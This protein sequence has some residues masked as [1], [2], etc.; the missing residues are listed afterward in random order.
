VRSPLLCQTKRGICRKCYGTDFTTNEP[1]DIGMP[2]GVVA[3]QSIGE[4]GTQ[5]TMRVRH[6]GGIVISDVTQGLPRVEELLETRTPKIISPIAEI[7]GK[8]KIKEDSENELYQIEIASLDKKTTKYYQIPMTQKLHIKNGQLITKGTQLSEGYLDIK[9]VLEIRGIRS[10]Q[11]YL[12]HEIQNVY[13]SQGI[14]IHDK[15]FEVIIRKMSDKIIIDDEGD[16]NFLMGEAVNKDVFVEE[17]KKIVAKGGKPASGKAKV[18]GITNASIFTDSW[19][20]AASFQNTTNVLTRSSIKGQ[21]D[22]LY[23]LKENVIIGRLIPVTQ[24]LIKKYYG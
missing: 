18:L 11:T 23:G 8:V 10:T 13:E 19:L 22:Y 21:M 16:T 2:V 15:H 12:L 14:G 6:F 24:Q 7:E 1:V 9:E 4:P 5:L 20:S 17:N 3:A